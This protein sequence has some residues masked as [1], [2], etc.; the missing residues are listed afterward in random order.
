MEL[1]GGRVVLIGLRLNPRCVLEVPPQQSRLER[2]YR[3]IAASPYSI[4][5]L[6]H[7]SLS[8]TGLRV[9]RFNMPFEL[10]IAVAVALSMPDA[11]S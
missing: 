2:L 10:A 11:G 1:A 4:H 3:L 7:V 5:D 8:G 9:P 6:S